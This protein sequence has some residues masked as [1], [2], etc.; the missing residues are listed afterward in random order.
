MFNMNW[1]WVKKLLEVGL[2]AGPTDFGHKSIDAV[3]DTRPFDRLPVC[4]LK[5]KN[6]G[7]DVVAAIKLA[8]AAEDDWLDQT[9]HEF[10]GCNDGALSIAALGGKGYPA[11][12]KSAVPG[13]V[14]QPVIDVLAA[15][16]EVDPGEGQLN[17]IRGCAA[18][19]SLP[20][21]ESGTVLLANQ[22]AERGYSKV[23]VQVGTLAATFAVFDRVN[24][25]NMYLTGFHV[26]IPTEVSDIDVAG[27]IRTALCQQAWFKTE[28]FMFWKE[29]THPPFTDDAASFAFALMPDDFGVDVQGSNAVEVKHVEG[30]DEG[31]VL[32][33]QSLNGEFI[34]ELKQSDYWLQEQ[35]D[36]DVVSPL[37]QQWEALA[38]DHFPNKD[39]SDALR[40]FRRREL[41]REW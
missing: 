21:M 40:T 30:L 3:S 38:E 7:G 9:K 31:H 8:K 39:P 33:L 14:V 17:P 29:P 6:L 23:P 19:L 26:P 16:H 2:F 20:L 37:T 12:Q 10:E 34:D 15:S 41:N 25:K 24:F 22:A 18:L 11:V 1:L 13:A 4:T 5:N 27:L 36:N 35:V 32:V 28:Q